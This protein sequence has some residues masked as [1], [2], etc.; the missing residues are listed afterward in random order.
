MNTSHG[1]QHVTQERWWPCDNLCVHR[2]MAM[3][4]ISTYRSHTHTKRVCMLYTHIHTLAVSL[5][6]VCE[7]PPDSWII[8]TKTPIEYIHQCCSPHC[9]NG[10]SG[11]INGCEILQGNRAWSNGGQKKAQAAKAQIHFT[12]KHRWLSQD[13]STDERDRRGGQRS[14]NQIWIQPYKDKML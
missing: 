11:L 10:H 1:L 12:Q 2:S 8:S 7:P 14:R 6:S 3:P 9:L 13:P 4:R 5:H